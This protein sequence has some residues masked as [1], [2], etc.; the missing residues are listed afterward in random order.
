[1]FTTGFKFFFGLAVALAA[2]AIVYGYTSGGTHVG[3]ISMAGKAVWATTSA[4]VCWQL[5]PR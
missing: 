5:W 2:A 1:M 4:T 3:P